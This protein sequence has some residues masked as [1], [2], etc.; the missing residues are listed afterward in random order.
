MSWNKI[1]ILAL[2][3]S[4]LVVGGCMDI[5]EHSVCA[6]GLICPPH[7]QCA[8]YQD[9]CITSPCGNGIIDAPA[10]ETCDDGNIDSGDGCSEECLIE[11]VCG[12]GVIDAG[13]ECD[14]GNLVD[15]DGCGDCSLSRR[16][17]CAASFEHTG[18]DV[19]RGHADDME[20][21][22]CAASSEHTGALLRT[23]DVHY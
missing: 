11:G 23:D 21:L 20:V 15:T 9:V 1:L 12:N 10:G 13:E 7:L 17:P 3:A 4:P 8:A 2:L 18:A 5:P 14:D 6:S 19:G 16:L 22:P